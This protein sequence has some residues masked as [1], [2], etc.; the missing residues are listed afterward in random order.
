MVVF[1]KKSA[2]VVHGGIGDVLDV[3]ADGGPTI[4]VFLISERAQLQ[5]SIAVGLIE[6]TLLEFFNDN[7]ALHF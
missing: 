6:V 4:R 3:F 7:L 5:P 1:L 2:D